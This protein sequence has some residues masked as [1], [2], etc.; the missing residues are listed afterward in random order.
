M[1]RKQELLMSYWD[2]EKVVRFKPEEVPGY[3]GWKW[4]DC[5]CCAGIEWGGE[6]P[7]ECRRCWGDGRLCLHKKSGAYALYPGGPFLGNM[8]GTR[9]RGTR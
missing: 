8:G 4:I 3:P 2:G 7:V 5:G 1:Y 9:G 6:H